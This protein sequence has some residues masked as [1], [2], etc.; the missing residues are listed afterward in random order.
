MKIGEIESGVP[1][2]SEIYSKWATLF[3]KMKVDDSFQVECED[4]QR[5][6]RAQCVRMNACR[7]RERYSP[8]FQYAIRMDL[9]DKDKFRF[10]RLG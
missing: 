6:K 1:L 3:K 7:Y 8:D 4:G 10:W 9:E 2:Q 5:K